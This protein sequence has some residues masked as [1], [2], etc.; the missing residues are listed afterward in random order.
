[1]KT[2]YL[3]A[4][5]L[6]TAATVAGLNCAPV[7]PAAPP[8]TKSAE[9]GPPMPPPP[10]PAPGVALPPFQPMPGTMPPGVG[11]PS[12]AVLQRLDLAIAQVRARQLRTDNGFWT[13]FHGILGL[14]PSV[15]L[16][17]PL[18]GR[19][20]NALDYMASGGKI[21]GMHFIP[22]A[23]GLDVETGPGTFEKQGH[24]DQFIAEM[25]EWNVAPERKFRVG[26]K[27]YTFGDFL[28]YSKAH[29]SAT[30]NQELEWA[31]VII[32]THYGTDAEW[33][34]AYGEK[35]RFEDLVRAELD[36]DLDKAACGGTHLLFGLTWVYHLHCQHG[37]KPVGVWKDVADRIA[38]Y[39]RKAR[40]AQ[41][42]DG[43]FSTDFFKERTNAP[44]VNRRI[45]T[46][47]HVLEWLAL[48]MTDDELKEPW[49]QEAANALAMLFLGNDHTPL[50]G[51]GMYHAVH[52]M[53]IYTSRVYGADKLPDASL[54]PHVPPPPG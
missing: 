53:L 13:V 7:D 39:K 35:V 37:G 47:G 1:M 3:I 31:L 19:K 46:T 8:D 29:A 28:R 33:T 45:N 6:G 26:G 9:Q 36:K 11:K 30:M 34:N 42:P 38:T 49:V 5:L 2:R 12:D 40:E 21:P 24:Q 27:D 18:T 43:T 50:E 25:V 32:G 54:K 4:V 51:G 41:T 44:D 16:E 52:G 20:V 48:A 17:D 22:T 23:D 15:M 10:G 14:G